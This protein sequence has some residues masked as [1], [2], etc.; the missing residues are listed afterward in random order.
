MDERLLQCFSRKNSVFVEIDEVKINV[1]PLT[2]GVTVML[3]Q[4]APRVAV[5]WSCN[6]DAVEGHDK[7]RLVPDRLTF[8][9]GQFVPAIVSTTFWKLTGSTVAL[10]SA[11]W[12]M[13]GESPNPM[14]ALLE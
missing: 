14:A 6:A 3:L 8:T 2:V 13:T 11:T 5:V 12:Q 7:I 10:V 1:F 4:F 9:A